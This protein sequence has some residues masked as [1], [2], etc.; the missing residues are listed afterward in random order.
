MWNALMLLVPMLLIIFRTNTFSTTE[1][2]VVLS[3]FA[4]AFFGMFWSS[5]LGFLHGG[6][7]VWNG[8]VVRQSN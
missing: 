4:L 1:S 5:R 8:K 2:P 7:M 3:V 6:A